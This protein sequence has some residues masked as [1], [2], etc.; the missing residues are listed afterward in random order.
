MAATALLEL[1]LIVANFLV[2]LATWWGCWCRLP[3]LQLDNVHVRHRYRYRLI[4]VLTPSVNC[5]LSTVQLIL[6][7]SIL[8][9]PPMDCKFLVYFTFLLRSLS[10][11]TVLL[12]CGCCLINCCVFATSQ[13]LP[14]CFTMLHVWIRKAKAIYTSACC[15]I[16]VALPLLAAT[17]PIDR[18]L[19]NCCL[20]DFA[21]L[22][23]AK[24]Q[25]DIAQHSLGWL[26]A[27]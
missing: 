21:L 18:L 13:L 6:M 27:S 20:F 22:A 15:R 26:L 9:L 14:F 19:I 24:A 12:P 7:F 3:A 4:L 11:R 17:V 2:V 25:A 23:V 10:P 8:T 1:L 5:C 16:A